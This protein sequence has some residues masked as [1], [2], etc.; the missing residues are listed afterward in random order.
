MSLDTLVTDVKEK[1]LETT[2]KLSENSLYRYAVDVGSGWT[3]YTPVYAAQELAS[4]KDIDT[5]V[6]TRLI[7]LAAHAVAMRPAGLLRNYM[8]K[9][10]KVTS[11]SPLIEKIKVN[12]AGVKIVAC[13][14]NKFACDLRCEGSCHSPVAWKAM[15][16]SN[17]I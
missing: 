17:A 5:I 7:G 10:W 3:Y 14:F 1:W 8:A 4:G 16:G 11:E 2:V 15:E 13:G 12:V 6:K 9:K